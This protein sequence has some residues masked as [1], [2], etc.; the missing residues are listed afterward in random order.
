MNERINTIHVN[1]WL[2][3][4][5]T[6]LLTSYYRPARGTSEMS[7]EVA[8]VYKEVISV[9]SCDVI[10]DDSWCQSVAAWVDRINK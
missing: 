9:A 1:D 5:L 4:L 7:C 8:G 2:I 6:Y 3:D 10:R